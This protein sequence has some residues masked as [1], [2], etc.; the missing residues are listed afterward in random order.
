M[1]DRVTREKW[2][3]YDGREH[4]SEAA[5]QS[6]ESYLKSVDEVQRVVEILEPKI[7]RQHFSTLTKEIALFPYCY[8]DGDRHEQTQFLNELGS[9]IIENWDALKQALEDPANAEDE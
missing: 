8:D 3:S 7:R 9:L 6:W 1:V 5:A 4:D 2:M